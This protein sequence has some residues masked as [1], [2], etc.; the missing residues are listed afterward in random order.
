MSSASEPRHATRSTCPIEGSERPPSPGTTRLGSIDADETLT[1]TLRIRRRRDVPPPPVP[2]NRRGGKHLSRAA[3]AA[4]YG[5]DPAELEQVAQFAANHGLA[6]TERDSGRRSVILSGSAS[7]IE[8]AFGVELKQYRNGAV[9]HRGFEGQVH[10]PADVAGIIEHV[11]GLDDRPLGRPLVRQA[12][13]PLDSGVLTPGQVASLYDFPAVSAAGQTIGII[14]F[15][16]GYRPDD[17]QAYFNTIAN[18]PVP[19]ITFVSIDGGSNQAPAAPALGGSPLHGYFGTDTSQHVNYVA[20]DGHLHELY[21]NP[22]SFWYDNDLTVATGGVVPATGTVLTGYWGTDNSQHVNFIGADGHVHEFYLEPGNPWL[23]N[24]LTL[25][26]KGTMPRGDSPLDGY[27][28]QDS[29]QHVDFIGTDGHIHELY[30]ATGSPWVC[31]DITA[32]SGSPVTAIAGS[33]LYGYFGSDTSQHLQFIGIDGHVHELY[34]NPGEG[35]RSNDLTAAS[36]GISPIAGSPLDG[37]W[38]EDSSQHVNFIGTDGHIHELYLATGAAWVCNDINFNNPQ[39]EMALDIAIAGSAAPGARLVIYMAPN[40]EQGWLDAFSTAIHDSVNT[41]S[42]ISLSWGGEEDDM[43]DIISGLSPILAEAAALGVTL[44]SSSGDNGSENPAQVLYPASDPSITGCGGTVIGDVDGLFFDQVAWGGSGGGFS[45]VFAAPGWQAGL[46]SGANR[47]VPDIA[48]SA[49]NGYE[50]ILG[51]AS[52]GYWIGTSAVAPL[53]AGLVALLNASLGSPVGFL[54]PTLYGLASPSVF[55]DVTS[56]SNGGY[57]AGPGWDA[58][59]GLGSVNGA[60]LA[61]AMLGQAGPSGNIALRAQASSALLDAVV[62]DATGALSVTSVDGTGNW[63]GPFVIQGPGY[64][65]AGAKVALGYQVTDNQLDAVLVDA[66]GTLAVSSV[67]GIGNWAAPLAISGAGYA[68]PGAAVAMASQVSMGQLDV[69]LVDDTGTLTVFSVDGDGNWSV[70]QAIS[71]PGYAPP[72][73]ALAMAHQVNDGQ[74]DVVLVDNTG[75]LS[76]FQV[77]GDGTWSTPYAASAPG[78]APPGANV[79]LHYQA[80]LGQLDVVLVDNT[81]TLSVFWVAGD[82]NWGGPF[83]ISAPGYAP[84]AAAVAMEHQI[85]WNQL[86]VAVIDNTGML[87]VFYVLGDGNW[88]GP[89][90]VSQPG[91]AVPG[92]A[93]AL[94]HQ[95]SR[96]QLDVVVVDTNGA[97][98]VF[99]VVDAG[100]WAGPVAAPITIA[101]DEP[102]PRRLA[103]VG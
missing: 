18:L 60:P 44:F 69:A 72:G 56:G 57:T 3:F 32:A 75:T 33:A 55:D 99:Y 84:P 83:P 41:P 50:L 93:V 85:N 11:A 52:G 101:A 61:Y 78:Y 35:W 65:P 29:S 100:T 25:A 46:P 71:A 17:V 13:Q 19:E 43:G 37:Y 92:G 8:H 24:D 30:L 5:A 67:D 95:I 40:N 90:P 27:W 64:A 16:G 45:N 63:G 73:A 23:D 20:T 15:G 1:V 39:G 62:V 31:N 26:A 68:P 87:S 51:D 77:D 79:A 58:V 102:Q 2:W 54:N 66:T 36:N 94:A 74:L 34:A 21:A 48:G 47:G 4:Q 82:G 76:V 9:R 70:P 42:V 49:G 96:H 80:S 86:N 98:S 81:G 7:Q 12:A 22:G 97:L 59:T 91:F 88:A 89:V 6:T 53:Y 28:Q 38:Q 10:V 103:K 14:E